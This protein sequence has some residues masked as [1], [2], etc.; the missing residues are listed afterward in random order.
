MSY[1][2]PQQF[3]PMHPLTTPFFK[4]SNMGKVLT[5]TFEQSTEEI[6]IGIDNR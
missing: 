3:L 6:M 5:T 2:V 1:L 4:G